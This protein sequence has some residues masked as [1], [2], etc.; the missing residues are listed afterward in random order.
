MKLLRIARHFL[1]HSAVVI[2]VLRLNPLGILHSKS[3]K[4]AATELSFAI[5]AFGRK[6]FGVF[7]R[8]YG[9]RRTNILILPMHLSP[10]ADNKLFSHQKFRSETNFS[11]SVRKEWR[12]RG[13]ANTTGNIS[14][15]TRAIL[16]ADFVREMKG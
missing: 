11:H 9:E 8:I 5:C 14:N 15:C 10:W 16:V 4:V 13:G 1:L 3:A 6:L 12:R 7:A 2:V